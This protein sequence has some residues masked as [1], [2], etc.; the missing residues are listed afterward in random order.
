[1]CHHA[2]PRR[3][4]G[5]CY[6]SFPVEGKSHAI[7]TLMVYDWINQ[8]KI[9]CTPGAPHQ[10]GRKKSHPSVHFLHQSMQCALPLLNAIFRHF[11]CQLHAVCVIISSLGGKIRLGACIGAWLVARMNFTHVCPQLSYT[12]LWC[13][14]LYSMVHPTKA[15]STMV[16]SAFI[17]RN[18]HTKEKY[19]TQNNSEKHIIIAYCTGTQSRPST[20]LIGYWSKWSGDNSGT[21]VEKFLTGEQTDWISQ[22][23]GFENKHKIVNGGGKNTQRVQGFDRIGKE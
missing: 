10:V 19:C 22:E 8:L 18:W 23:R 16:H 15:H 7:L 2:I 5:P 12:P 6:A 14:H 20:V 3:L 21:R 1:M 4:D 17:G 9:G 13:T 11:R